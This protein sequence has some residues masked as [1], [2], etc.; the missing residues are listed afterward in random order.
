LH[1]IILIN[2][3]QHALTHIYIHISWPILTYLFT[4]SLYNYSEDYYGDLDLKSI[5]KSE[6]LAGLNTE[7]RTKSAPKTKAATS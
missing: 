3:Q 2:S 7:G 1:S 6:L 5:R 4:S